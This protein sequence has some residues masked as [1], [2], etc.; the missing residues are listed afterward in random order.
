M[1]IL[2]D[3]DSSLPPPPR[4]S[5]RRGPEVVT[6]PRQRSRQARQRETAPARDPDW[7]IAGM[8]A[9]R[10]VGKREFRGKPL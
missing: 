2:I 1:R 9:S 3:E 5:S 8:A 6:T 7:M 4:E 10:Y